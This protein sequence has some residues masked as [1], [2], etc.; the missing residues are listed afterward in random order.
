M[1]ATVAN[2]LSLNA[3]STN[4]PT[5]SVVQLSSATPIPASKLVIVNT[6]TSAII[7]STGAS[8][9]EIGLVAV[10]PAS[11]VVLQLGAVMPQGTRL[12]LNALVTAASAGVLAVSLLP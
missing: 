11:T 1:S 2:I 10:G 4:V 3:A 6:T 9:S 7:I 12:S 8:G 5:G